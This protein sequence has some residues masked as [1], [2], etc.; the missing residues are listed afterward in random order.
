MMDTALVRR[1]DMLAAVQA[2][3][4]EQN[5]QYQ[6]AWRESYNLRQ[7][8]SERLA[9]IAEREFRFS[10]LVTTNEVQERLTSVPT[11]ETRP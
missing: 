8:E 2:F 7:P 11:V 6:K 9:A 3:Y 1:S 10:K 5:A 4:D